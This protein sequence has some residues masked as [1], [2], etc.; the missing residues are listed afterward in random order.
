[1]AGEFTA[2]SVDG[3]WSFLNRATPLGHSQLEE[4]PETQE[5]IERKTRAN[6][7]AYRRPDGSVHIPTEC[8]IVTARKPAAA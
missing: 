3:Y 5:T 2:E 6:I 7:A 4:D 8:V 1:M